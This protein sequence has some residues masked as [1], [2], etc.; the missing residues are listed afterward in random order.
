MSSRN[1]LSIEREW[2]ASQMHRS[3][4]H[5]K[6]SAGLAPVSVFLRA[7]P[8]VAAHAVE[9]AARGHERAAS[10][11]G[12]WP[13]PGVF[14]NAI[15]L[16]RISRQNA[17]RSFPQAGA[18]AIDEYHAKNAHAAPVERGAAQHGYHSGNRY[19]ES[20]MPPFVFSFAEFGVPVRGLRVGVSQSHF[21][22]FVHIAFASYGSR[23]S[24]RGH[25]TSKTH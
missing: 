19:F 2:A 11:R 24:R 14:G 5:A 15:V 9:Q 20:A 10:V 17:V 22:I 1:L 13:Y 6:V 4:F 3:H 7:L 23:S 18:P 8:E 21:R 25:T 12:R 16:E